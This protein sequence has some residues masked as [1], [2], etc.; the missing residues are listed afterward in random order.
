MRE[1]RDDLPD[2]APPKRRILF[3]DDQRE[4]CRVARILFSRAGHEVE[5][6]TDVA[7]G[8]EVALRFRP[9]VLLADLR[10]PDPG[11]GEALARQI[12]AEPAL[13]QVYLCAITGSTDSEE[14][15]AALAAGFDEILTKP[16]DYDGFLKRLESMGTQHRAD[17]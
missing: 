15:D 9:D 8:L 13:R 10:M 11:D 12:K 16:L 2:P 7:E 5:T 14:H 1:S 17:D 3:V 6:A 4:L